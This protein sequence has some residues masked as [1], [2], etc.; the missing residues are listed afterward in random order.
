MN[1][2]LT[3]TAER[4]RPYRMVGVAAVLMAAVA[5]GVMFAVNANRPQP[6][7][8]LPVGSVSS[9]SAS[10]S[11]SSPGAMPASSPVST[12]VANAAAFTCSATNL[13]ANGSPATSFVDALRTGSHVGY[14][15]VVV[16]FKNGQPGSISIRPQA[17]TTFNQSPSGQAMKVLGRHGIL[18]IIRGADVHTSYAGA[19]DFKTKYA[20]LA[21]MR[22]LEDFEGQVSLGL[23]VNQ[24]SCYRVAVLANPAR[25]VIDVKN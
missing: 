20:G 16:Q 23:G 11:Q 7:G 12:V 1:T 21:E 14:D 6:T 9:P 25:L 10:S 2:F 13:S 3:S 19:R 4:S 24:T 5:I 8:A 18:V 15:R 17:G 22:V